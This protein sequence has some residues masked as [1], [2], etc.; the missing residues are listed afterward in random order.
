MVGTENVTYSKLA[1]S[2]CLSIKAGVFGLYAF[3]P[4]FPSPYP[5]N[6]IR[7]LKNSKIVLGCELNPNYGTLICKG[8]SFDLLLLTIR[9]NKQTNITKIFFRLNSLGITP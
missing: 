8:C 5:L 7:G 2:K 6:N 1:Y 9:I 4:A 3:Y